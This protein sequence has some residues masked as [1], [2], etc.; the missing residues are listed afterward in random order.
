M[1]NVGIIG[2]GRIGRVHGESISKFVPN[3]RVKAVADPFLNDNSIAWAKS[4]GIEETYTDYKKILAD[5]EIQE[6]YH[7]FLISSDSGLTAEAQDGEYA[8]E[9][10]GDTWVYS[11]RI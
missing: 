7:Q 2:V 9:Q 1:I 3:A 11:I 4:M 10:I 6:L 5:P 8:T